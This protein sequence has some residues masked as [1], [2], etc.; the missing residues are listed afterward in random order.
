MCVCVC[1]CVCVNPYKDNFFTLNIYQSIYIGVI[2]II[3]GNG[4][5]D[6]SSNP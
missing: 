3:V 2:V 1:V 4:D 5:G 6:T